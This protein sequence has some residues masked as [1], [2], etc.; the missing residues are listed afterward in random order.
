MAVNDLLPAGLGFVSATPE[1][2]SY[3]EALGQWLVGTLAGNASAT[4]TITALVVSPGP[5]TN[6]ATISHSDQ[7]DPGPGND[8]AS[9]TETPPQADLALTKV[10]SDATPN[11]GDTITYTTTVT[12]K[13]GRQPRHAATNVTVARPAA[14]GTRLRVDDTP[15]RGPMTSTASP[16][17]GRWGPSPTPAT[18]DPDHRRRVVSRADQIVNSATISRR[19]PSSTPAWPTTP[20]APRRGLQQESPT[21]RLTKKRR[22][23]PTPN[24]ATTRSPSRS[25]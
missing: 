17:S 10:V 19:R 5:Q 13:P 12:R 11:V 9:A 3:D 16:A 23:N 7:F 15:A 8:S 21:W 18:A 4:L 22:C 20:P 14:R 1:Q 24:V 25:P 6:T 2:G